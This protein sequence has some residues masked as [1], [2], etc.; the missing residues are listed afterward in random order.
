MALKAPCSLAVRFA[1]QSIIDFSDVARTQHLA[2]KRCV[3]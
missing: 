1:A 3:A 2:K